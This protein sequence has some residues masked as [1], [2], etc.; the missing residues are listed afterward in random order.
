M[1]LESKLPRTLGFKYWI[2]AKNF[3]DNLER[4]LVAW[5]LNGLGFLWHEN[6]IGPHKWHGQAWPGPLRRPVSQ[7]IGPWG[8][9]VASWGWW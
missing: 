5:L 3:R 8:D 7:S 2:H 6:D 9:E 1:T 4:L